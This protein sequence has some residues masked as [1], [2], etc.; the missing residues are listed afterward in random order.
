MERR[1]SGTS[2]SWHGREGVLFGGTRVISL[3]RLRRLGASW[4][5]RHR[6]DSDKGGHVGDAL[7]EDGVAVFDDAY[8]V[9]EEVG[10][11]R[12]RTV[13]D[14]PHPPDREALGPSAYRSFGW[15]KATGQDGSTA[16]AWLETGDSYAFTPAAAIRAVEETLRPSGRGALSPSVAFGANF[17]V[18]HPRHRVHRR[19]P[20]PPPADAT[21]SPSPASRWV[22]TDAQEVQ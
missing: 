10:S 13:L 4:S 17:R 14:P 21:L 11:S 6:R 3:S 22:S 20:P 2:L 16:E 7:I 9:A 19:P 5:R 15:A 12:T 18:H 8:Q 1:N